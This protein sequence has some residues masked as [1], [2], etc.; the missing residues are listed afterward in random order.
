MARRKRTYLDD[1]YHDFNY[2]INEHGDVVFLNDEGLE[3][4]EAIYKVAENRSRLDSI[5][6]AYQTADKIITGD[7]IK[8]TITDDREFEDIAKNN[9]REIIYNANLIEDL[10]TSTLVSMNGI[11]YHELAHVLFS[12]RE[13]STLGRYVK[14]GNMKRAFN[15]LEEARI[16]RLMVAKYPSTRLYLEAMV[17]DY[18][19]QGEQDTWQDLF[20]IITGRRYLDLELRQSI[21]D[22]FINAYGAELA[23]TLSNIINEYSLLSFPTDFTRGMELIAQLTE[24][25]GKDDTKSSM[26]DTHSHGTREVLKQGRPIGAKEQERLQQRQDKGVGE[27]LSGDSKDG[28]TPNPSMGVGG[29]NK[30]N[31][32]NEKSYSDTDKQLADQL[33]ERL[34][35][36][37]ADNTIK[38]DVSHLRKS[39]IGDDEMR[40][41]LGKASTYT[42]ACSPSALSYARKFAIEL[43]RMVRNNDPKWERDMPVGR[44][45]ISRTMSPNIN[46]I[47]R[48]FDRWDTGNPN[49][50]IEAVILLD[51]SGSMGGYMREVCEKAWIIKRGIEA[52]DGNVTVY[53]FNSY[54]QL[55]YS[56]DDKAKPRNYSYVP[57]TG[58]TNPL[59]AL[60][61]AERI[62]NMS[63]KPIKVLFVVTDGMWDSTKECDEV[64]NRLTKSGAIT[65][66]VYMGDYL[67]LKN[68]MSEARKGDEYAITLLKELRHK[69][70][71]FKAVAEPKHV[72]ELA[73]ELVKSKVGARG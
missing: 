53:N 33:S 45:N 44:L 20:P 9:G 22:K 12:P 36:I 71:I 64:I 59:T 43:E 57:A 6:N 30:T 27:N 67:H 56:K 48:V 37:Y 18:A 15:M 19:F 55:I 4:S 65:S 7:D 52:I 51:N 3:R 46:N 11:N 39:I 47:D 49:T 68:M 29:D 8:V 24:I 38:N 34:N 2:N 66:V 69:A 26:K 63:N 54:S 58:S 31:F 73:V 40:S 32:S 21:A 72:L 17:L 42:E 60:V 41:V 35:S 10:D 25:V 5:G 28:D 13:G 23:Q 1:M 61:E 62:L 50:D 14:Q 16:E 70:S